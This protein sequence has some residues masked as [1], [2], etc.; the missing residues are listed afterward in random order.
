MTFLFGAAWMGH[1]EE[2]R[3]LALD[4]AVA[5]DAHM[6]RKEA[7]ALMGL[8]PADL[9]KQLAGRDP[10]NAWRLANLPA[11]FWLAF[12]VARAKRIGAELM[13][14]DQLALLKGAAALGPRLLA[15][16]LPS[17]KRQAS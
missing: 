10:L 15:A 13:T 2:S 8:H 14:A 9:S 6:E 7:A 4:I 3:Q 17:T 11:C 5:L 1:T 16:V 12:L